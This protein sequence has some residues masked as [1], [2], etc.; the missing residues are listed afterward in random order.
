M[1]NN[2]A[3]QRE[4]KR[5]HEC[6]FSVCTC[7]GKGGRFV[8]F[9]DLKDFFFEIQHVAA[10]ITDKHFKNKKSTRKT[11]KNRDEAIS[12]IVENLDLTLIT[13]EYM[14]VYT[15]SDI[16]RVLFSHQCVGWQW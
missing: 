12:N 9:L 16:Q 11:S 4:P 10:T 2:N 1:S 5:E 7:V 8:I 15:K 13:F 6:S 3:T 14:F